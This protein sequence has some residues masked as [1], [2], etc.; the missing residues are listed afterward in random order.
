[1]RSLLGALYELKN[2]DAAAGAEFREV[3]AVRTRVLGAA[4]PETL[5]AQQALASFLVRRGESEQGVALIRDVL[6]AR[7]LRGEDTT[8]NNL[9]ARNVLAYALEDQG[10]LVE[11]EAELRRVVAAQSR[12]GGP[13]N[14]EA[15][16]PRNNLAM[17][18]LKQKRAAAALVE[19]DALDTW[20]RGNLPAGHPYF[21]V[22]ASNRGECLVQLGRWDEARRVLEGAHRDLAAKF[23]PNHERTRTAAARLATV[24]RHFGDADG[25]AAL[26]A[27]PVTP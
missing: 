5:S 15:I 3:I 24:L 17:L 10:R 7:R 25:A 11:A 27:P 20:M 1:M 21:A 19:F 12:D 14:A 9:L 26:T 2:D 4:H 18:L 23:G 6:E 22:F 13:A 16:G 8:P